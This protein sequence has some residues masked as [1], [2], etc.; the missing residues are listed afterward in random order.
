MILR[1]STGLRAALATNYGMGAMMDGGWI[2]VYDTPL[3][4]TP[5]APP[6]ALPLARITDGGRVFIPVDD[7]YGAGLRLQFASPYGLT[8]R[9]G[10]QW[11]MVG[12]RTGTAKWFRWYWRDEDTL[13]YSTYY[14]RV[15]GDLDTLNSLAAGRIVST[16]ITPD[17]LL[18]IEAFY[19]EMA[20]GSR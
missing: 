20:G 4:D 11:R 17:T 15:D 5:D 7:P 18:P 16:T 19:L 8:Q 10:S 1:F 13:G 9:D 2:A 6:G 12:M 14:P 3:P